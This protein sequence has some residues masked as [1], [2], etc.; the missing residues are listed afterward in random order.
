MQRLA[1]L[2]HDMG[3]PLMKTTDQNGIDHF[4]GHPKVSAELAGKILRRL[5]FDNDTIRK[6]TELVYWH[7]CP[8][9]LSLIHI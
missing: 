1:V 4:H 6:V 3:K 7:E 5:R 2:F 9:E 8:W